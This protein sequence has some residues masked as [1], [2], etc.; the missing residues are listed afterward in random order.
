M[1][2]SV[3]ISRTLYHCLSLSRFLFFPSLFLYLSLSLDLSF[4][5]PLFISFSLSISIDFSLP[6]NNMS[7]IFNFVSL[8]RDDITHAQLLENW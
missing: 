6:I 8:N 3:Y 4:Y 1:S 2:L 5:F 7:V